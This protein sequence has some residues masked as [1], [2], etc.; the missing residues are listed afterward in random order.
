MEAALQDLVVSLSSTALVLRSQSQ[1][2]LQALHS[3]EK[4]PNQRIYD[5]AK[6]AL[7]LLSEVRLAL[8]P[9]QMILAD[10]FFG[11]SQHQSC[12]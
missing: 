12:Q 4:L 10:H 3:T 5:L 2:L 6:N 7:D 9:G 1:D 8:E 11:Q